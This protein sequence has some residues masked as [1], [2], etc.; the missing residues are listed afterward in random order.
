[1]VETILAQDAEGRAELS[2]AAIDQD[3]IGHHGEPDI[4]VMDIET[5]DEMTVN[6]V[7]V[8]VPDLPFAANDE[9]V[10]LISGI[11]ATPVME[12]YILYN[13]VAALLREKNISVY[14]S[15][16]GNYFTSL[17]I[18]WLCH[19]LIHQPRLQTSYWLP[20]DL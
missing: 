4:E 16:V 7:D 6:M 5:A 12:Q 18:R 17:E 10:V 13:K 9:V 14:R 20:M 11:G 1:M 2:L 3:R 19:M 8:V 15:Y